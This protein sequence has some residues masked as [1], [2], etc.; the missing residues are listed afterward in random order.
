M[1]ILLIAALMALATAC[2]HPLEIVGEGDILSATGERDCRLE[3]HRAGLKNCSENLVKEEYNETY[4]AQP[5]PGWKFERWEN[6][7]KDTRVNFCRFDVPGSA[8]FA[9]WGGKA[10]P[11][12]AV[13]VEEEVQNESCEASYSSDDVFIV[14]LS[15]NS[16][17]SGAC[18]LRNG[19]EAIANCVENEI[20]A[21]F[22][23]NP[24]CLGEIDVF[25]PGTNQENGDY[26]QFTSIVS[27]TPGRTYL[28]LQYAYDPTPLDDALEYDKG[29]NDADDALEHLLYTLRTRFEDSNVRVFGHSKGSHTVARVAQRA[30][31]GAVQFFAFAQPGRTPSSYRGAPGY[32]EKL[33]NNL[34]VLTWQNDEVKFYSGGSNGKQFPEIWGFPGYVN[35][36]GGGQTYFPMRID[37]H[38]NYGGNYVKKDFP[39]CATG[40][41]AAMGI[42]SE[43]VYQDGVRYVPY[44]WGNAECTSIA[45]NMMDNGNPGEKHYIGY[46]GPRT[47]SCKDTVGTVTASYALHYSINI[48]DQDDC[49]Y[50]M[51]LAFKGLDFGTNRAD[52]S[53][54]K[55][56]STRDTYNRVKTGTIQ[57]PYH[58]RINWKAHMEDVSG[59]FSKC[60]N[61]AGAKSEGYIHSLSVTF[62]H[63]ATRARVT[64]KL[65]GN[66]EGIEY[67]WPLKVAGKNNVAWRK[68]SG[69]WDL[70]FG[71]PPAYPADALM[72]KGDT[73][74]NEKGEFYKWVHLVD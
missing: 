17:K 46:S 57:L 15:A 66:A 27:P 6:Y 42:T 56:S 45:Y 19:R 64:R 2:S 1:R 71:I 8:V 9:F 67:I 55:L 26:K 29:V 58:M 65:I 28:S 49:K 43:C 7:C 22:A 69:D 31:H 63:P 74:D 23:E 14:D 54:I 21:E 10:D 33:S 61:Y 51:E 30:Q 32:I 73:R 38:N 35:Q 34:V 41:K 36:G 40:N 50:H 3:E 53:T 70:H 52:G 16:E 47:G 60:I 12:R 11:L 4:Y 62:T 5:R 72:V 48:A 24:G 59:R 13:F 37:H 44:F 20:R 68:T 39:Y 18:A 25:V